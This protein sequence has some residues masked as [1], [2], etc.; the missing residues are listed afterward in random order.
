MVEKRENLADQKT[1][2]L[3]EMSTQRHFDSSLRF[4]EIHL[5]EVGQD[6]ELSLV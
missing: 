3:C 1:V 4:D 6:K 2:L 5:E